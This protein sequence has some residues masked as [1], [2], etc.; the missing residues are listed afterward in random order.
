MW[1]Y[2]LRQCSGIVFVV[3]SSDRARLPVARDELDRM[4]LD[5]GLRDRHVPLLILANKSDKPEVL[6]EVRLA[7]LFRL[8]D[9]IRNKNWHVTSTCA[10]SGEGLVQ[11]MDWLVKQIAANGRNPA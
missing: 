5:P 7:D 6:S 11:G 2:Y 3:D 10:L 8:H 4:L 1:S 9:K